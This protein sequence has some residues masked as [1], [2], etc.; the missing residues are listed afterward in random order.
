MIWWFK[1]V[2][3]GDSQ[4]VASDTTHRDGGET[5]AEAVLKVKLEAAES[6]ISR[7]EDELRTLRGERDR[8]LAML[9]AEQ[10]QRVHLLES[11]HQRGGL[12]SWF[13]RNRGGG[14]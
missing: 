5:V 12:F 11:G 3:N 8:L 2:L 6:T 10:A 7:L 13:R 9:E 14:E 4:S 1:K